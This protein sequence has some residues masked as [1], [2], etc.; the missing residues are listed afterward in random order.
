MRFNGTLTRWNSERGFGFIAPDQGGQDV[1]VHISAL[2]KDGLQPRIGERLSF[3]VEAGK[4]GRKRAAAVARP[5]RASA[6]RV[7]QRPRSP[8]RRREKRN[9]FAPAA[10]FVLL[11]AFGTYGYSEYSRWVD[12]QAAVSAAAQ[13]GDLRS[14][15]SPSSE[16]SFQCDGRTHCSQMTSCE[17]AVYFLKNCPGTK[18]DGD[19]DGIPCE[20]QFC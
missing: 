10:A 6:S 15:L 13:A 2:P 7:R 3:E 4:D 17:E 18:M 8:S 20:R 12:G 9:W 11:A 16:P 1:F 19:H 14:T 5:G